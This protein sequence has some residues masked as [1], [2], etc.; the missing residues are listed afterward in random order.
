MASV[1]T[2]ETPP[3]LIFDRDLLQ[4]RRARAV[5]MAVGT[6]APD[7][8]L[9]RAC[10]D[11]LD[12]VRLVKRRFPVAAVIGV[13][14]GAF[15]DALRAG[16]GHDLVV[17]VDPARALLAAMPGP[18]VQADEEALPFRSGAL[19][20]VVSVLTL[21][22]VNDVPGAL[23]QIRHALKPD[24]LFLATVLGGETLQE[25]RHAFVVA[26]SERDGGA[27][28]RVAPFADGRDLG[29]LLQRAGFALPVVDSDR[30]T[31]AYA[32]PLQLMRDLRGMGAGNVLVD[33]R[34]APLRRATLAR[35]CEIYAE[36]FARDDGKVLA[37]FEIV[38]LTA[39]APHADQPKPLRPGS[40]THRLADALRTTER[41]IGE[42]AG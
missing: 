8:L 38:T 19:D 32:H 18:K 4:M 1:M 37:S 7:Y 16:G 28:P 33:R 5:R 3:P 2:A 14:D 42:K 41:P 21:Q 6:A 31:V 25:L 23:A 35:A 22:T 10:E 15:T 26:E 17:A 36:R 29:G 24:G 27:S 40:A 30:F 39:W 13:H 12:R 11:L 34:R 9:T 20:L